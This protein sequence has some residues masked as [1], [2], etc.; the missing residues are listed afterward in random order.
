MRHRCWSSEEQQMPDVL[1]ED[2]DGEDANAS[3]DE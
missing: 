3:N 1:S 2:D